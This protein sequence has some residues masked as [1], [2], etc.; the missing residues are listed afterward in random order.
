MGLSTE[1]NK[2]VVSPLELAIS[3]P[4]INDVISRLNPDIIL[5]HGFVPIPTKLKEEARTE[6][7]SALREYEQANFLL[8]DFMLREFMPSGY[9]NIDARLIVYDIPRQ[10]EFVR[11]PIEITKNIA[12]FRAKMYDENLLSFMN[13][14]DDLFN[15]KKYVP[16]TMLIRYNGKSNNEISQLCIRIKSPDSLAEKVS[17]KIF[18]LYDNNPKK[19]NE[20]RDISGL[21]FIASDEKHCYDILKYFTEHSHNEFMVVDGSVKDY[22]KEPKPNG[23]K[24]LHLHLIDNRGLLHDIQIRTRKMEEHAERN[25]AIKAETVKNETR[26]RLNPQ[27]KGVYDTVK[28]TLAYI[29]SV[30]VPVLQSFRENWYN[31]K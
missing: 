20:I 12:M 4:K 14:D 29:F 21:R 5:R 15:L 7:R 11:Q 16:R 19:T 10:K 25:L 27:Y 18:G 1:N 28:E 3:K 17:N 2:K 6:F 24:S 22:V 23:Y 31:L 8:S 13:E 26:K 30:K 9:K